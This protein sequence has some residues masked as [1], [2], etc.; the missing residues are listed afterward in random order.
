VVIRLIIPPAFGFPER[1][2][3]NISVATQIHPDAG[4]AL[5]PYI[6]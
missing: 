4:L 1:N 5:I 6:G 3:H 2:Y